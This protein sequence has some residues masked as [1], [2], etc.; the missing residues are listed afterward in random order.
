[1]AKSNLEKISDLLPKLT[2]EELQELFADTRQQ[3]VDKA[4][5]ELKQAEAQ[6]NR[7]KAVKEEVTK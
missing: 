2:L 5:A 4:D 6:T 1:M 3:I 7:L